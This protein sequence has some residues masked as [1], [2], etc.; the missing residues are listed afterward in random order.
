MFP[1]WLARWR[2]VIKRAA[3]RLGLARALG[4][5][6]DNLDLISLDSV[7]AVVH[8]EGDVLDEERPYFVAESV[9][10]EAAL[11]A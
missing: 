10:V 11:F 8:L 6:T 2:L 4:V 7:G 9:R 3:A 1:S 5:A